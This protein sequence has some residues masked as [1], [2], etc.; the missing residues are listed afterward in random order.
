[1]K[2]TDTIKTKII[3]RVIAK[4]G[5]FLGDDIS[6]SLITIHHAGTKE[7]LASGQTKGGSG[8]I[9]EL[10]IQPR[11]RTVP[12]PV[13]GAS[14]F[15][16]TISTTDY[17]PVPLLITATG[18]GAGLQSAST[19]SATQWMVPGLKVNST[20]EP[21]VFTCELELPGLLVQIMEPPTHLNI[22]GALPQTIP[23]TANVA[24][25]CG[26]PID[27]GTDTDGTHTFPNPWQVDD[28]NVGCT[29]TCEGK[30]AEQVQ[31]IFDIANAPGRYT[32]QWQM[33]TPGF[34]TCHIYAYQLS[35][36]NTGCATVSFFK[37]PAKS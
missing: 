31:M 5:K 13:D 30:P 36:G 14:V 22:G 32:G 23:L 24:M 35:T 16:A 7:L 28:F 29:I 15:E 17:S 9:W 3:V 33:K 20:D 1:M 18:P 2:L 25:M 4:G 10:M 34:Y 19:V 26:C 27:N 11:P 8:D 37:I 6:G 21:V 12:I